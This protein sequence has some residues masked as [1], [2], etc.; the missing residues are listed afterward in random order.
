MANENRV[1]TNQ[2]R[3]IATNLKNKSIKIQSIY[4]SDCNEALRMGQ[5]C[6]SLCGLDIIDFKS[7]L[8]NAYSQMIER[9]S[10]FADFLN[11]TAEQY[12]KIQHDIE[13]SIN[14]NLKSELQQIMNN[15]SSIEVK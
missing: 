6:I 12:D 2:L 15:F 1:D 4:E 11:K 7:R 10:N 3:S 9:I 5:E 13:I 14:Q 8:N